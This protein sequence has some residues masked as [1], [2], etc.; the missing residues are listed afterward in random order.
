[1]V[2]TTPEPPTV[3]TERPISDAQRFAVA[4][5]VIAVIALGVFA[6][7]YH[8]PK[9]EL[10]EIIDAVVAI[11][12]LSLALSTWGLARYT[13]QSVRIS[14]NIIAAENLRHEQSLAPILSARAVAD[15]DKG[16]LDEYGWRAVR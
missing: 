13:Q 15:T 6:L 9:W 5:V 2:P 12:T 11:G 14:E 4:A 16:H 1:M 7:W 3:Q 10:S 8:S